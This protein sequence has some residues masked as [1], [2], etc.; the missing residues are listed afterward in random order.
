M[1][2][3]VASD[4]LERERRL[5]KEVDVAVLLF[6]I[7]PHSLKDFTVGIEVVGQIEA[8]NPGLIRSEL[9]RAYIAFINYPSQV[10]RLNDLCEIS[11]FLVNLL[12]SRY[13]TEHCT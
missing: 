2:G 8:E 3:V 10:L 5:G 6:E 9:H 7:R 4:T 12:G 11:D 13:S 1:K